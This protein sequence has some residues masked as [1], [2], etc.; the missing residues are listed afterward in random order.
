MPVVGL[1]LGHR[2]SHTLGSRAH[3]VA[4]AL[5]MATGLFR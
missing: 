4:G 3:V 5:L 1:L 2:V